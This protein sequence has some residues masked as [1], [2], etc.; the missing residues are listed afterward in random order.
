MARLL[1][2]EDQVRRVAKAEDRG[3]KLHDLKLG[4]ERLP[5]RRLVHNPQKEVEVHHNVDCGVEYQPAKLQ[6]LLILAPART[7]TPVDI[8]NGFSCRGQPIRW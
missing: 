1:L 2:H 8:Q 7:G 3:H 6:R 4:D 5:P